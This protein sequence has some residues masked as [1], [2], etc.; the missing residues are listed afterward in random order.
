MA[1]YKTRGGRW[2]FRGTLKL[3]DRT[4]KYS[5]TPGPLTPN[6]KQGAATAELYYVREILASGETR[7]GRPPTTGETR[8]V[9]LRVRV[10]ESEAQRYERLRKE[11]DCET[12]SDVIRLAMERL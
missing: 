8:N 11:H 9:L 6:T 7:I 5:G 1:V 2:R 12:L 4:V 3:A 10:S